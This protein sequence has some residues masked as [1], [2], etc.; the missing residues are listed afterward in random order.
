M[1]LVDSG[2]KIWVSTSVDFLELVWN[3]D[4]IMFLVFYGCEIL[5]YLTWTKI[6]VYSGTKFY[7]LFGTWMKNV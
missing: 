5:G 6:W 4:E 1:D 7:F 3:L 2:T